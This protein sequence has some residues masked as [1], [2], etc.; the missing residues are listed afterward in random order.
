MK[1]RAIVSLIVAVMMA[2]MLAGCGSDQSSDQS[3][4]NNSANSVK[5]KE[6]GS[7]VKIKKK[8]EA[9]KKKHKV[10]FKITKIV[11]DE[12]KVAKAIKKYNKS[13]TAQM[14]E[15]SPE[16]D[17]LQYCIAKY[18]VHFPE[19]FPDSDFGLTDVTVKIKV[20]APDGSDEIKADGTVYKKLSNTVEIGAVPQG[21]DFYSGQT[22]KGKVVYMIPKGS[23][24]YLLK[25]G[26]YYFK[27]DK[28]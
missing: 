10:K 21:Y 22:Y 27:P 8:A 7:W 6:T 16:N 9:D 1:K 13:G 24:D 2:V 28:E 5:A 20:K 25:A 19:D 3:E 18:K 14:L 15:T 4:D 23:A 26:G 17:K 12:A 11:T